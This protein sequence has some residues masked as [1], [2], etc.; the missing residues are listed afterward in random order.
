M[1]NGIL[2]QFQGCH[3][4]N[5]Q[6]CWCP[7]FEIL[8]SSQLLQRPTSCLWLQKSIGCLLTVLSGWILLASLHPTFRSTLSLQ[9]LYFSIPLKDKY[10]CFFLNYSFSRIA[11]FPPGPFVSYFPTFCRHHLSGVIFYLAHV[12]CP[13]GFIPLFYCGMVLEGNR[14]KHLI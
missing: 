6:L 12:V 3:D 11:R 4:T 10:T 14:S 2:V 5:S 1:I 8:C 9:S 7:N 13:H